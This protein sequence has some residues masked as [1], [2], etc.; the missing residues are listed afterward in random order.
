MAGAWCFSPSY[1]AL[2]ST[3]KRL[4]LQISIALPISFYASL[5]MPL[6]GVVNCAQPRESLNLL[7]TTT[8]IA[9]GVMVL[10][11]PRVLFSV[12]EYLVIHYSLPPMVLLNLYTYLF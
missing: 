3:C 2:L 8:A 4:P 5:A 10:S 11:R 6:P 12:S 7:S 9:Y 1:H